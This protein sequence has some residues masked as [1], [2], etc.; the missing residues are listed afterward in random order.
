ML[1]AW[2][3]SIHLRLCA[4]AMVLFKAQLHDIPLSVLSPTGIYFQCI[5]NTRGFCLSNR[6][7]PIPKSLLAAYTD[8]DVFM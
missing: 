4:V 1:P 8:A 7:S 2:I 3:Q 6:H 5:T